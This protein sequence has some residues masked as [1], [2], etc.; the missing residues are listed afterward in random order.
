MSCDF[1]GD[2]GRMV[3]QTIGQGRTE[4]RHFAQGS[5]SS[6]RARPQMDKGCA[7]DRGQMLDDHDADSGCTGER[8]QM[9][10]DLDADHGRKV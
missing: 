4:R 2:Q 9:S 8:R 10:Y 7:D 1:G 5:V 3:Q 6:L